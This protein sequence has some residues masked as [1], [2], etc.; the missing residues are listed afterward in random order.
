MLAGGEI[1]QP[2]GA[3]VAQRHRWR[4]AVT[5][6]VDHSMGDED[7]AAV[8]CLHDP[9]GA[10]DRT[11]KE[12]L[13]ASFYRACMQAGAHPKGHVI[14]RGELLERLL[15]HRRRAQRI[16][17]IAKR[18]IHAVTGHFDDDAA[19]LLDGLPRQRIVRS[20]CPGHPLAFLL[21]EPGAALDVGEKKSRQSWRAVHAENLPLVIAR[22][23]TAAG[24]GCQSAKGE[25]RLANNRG[26]GGIAAGTI[27]LRR[28]TA[29]DPR[30]DDFDL[31]A[32]KPRGRGNV[33]DRASERR[34]PRTPSTL[35][36]LLRPDRSRRS[37][38]TS[39]G[40]CLPRHSVEV[41]NIGCR[42]FRQPSCHAHQRDKQNARKPT[43]NKCHDQPPS[44]NHIWPP[45]PMVSLRPASNPRVRVRVVSYKKSRPMP[46]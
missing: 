20:E 36:Q 35:G 10:I 1:A 12:I 39:I 15:Q 23:S 45:F 46:D 34:T 26:P 31:F 44:R 19:V 33:P 30:G 6:L 38:V 14:R 9:R 25:R 11:A 7:L 16:Q 32:D 43:S 18:G 3:E 8:G 40:S 28:E 13:I 17:R 41:G 27:E 2:Y 21:P 4:Q 22:N 37:D 42:W 5:D 29:A 24:S